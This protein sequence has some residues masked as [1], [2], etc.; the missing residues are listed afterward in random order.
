[1]KRWQLFTLCFVL[2]LPPVLSQQCYYPNGSI[3][4]HTA[5]LS[6]KNPT[7]CCPPGF[8]CLSNGLCADINNGGTGGNSLP[9]L[10]DRESCTDKTWSSPNC[11]TECSN[12]T[13]DDKPLTI[14][15][16]ALLTFSLVAYSGGSGDG[17]Q[18]WSCNAELTEY[19]CDLDPGGSYSNCCDLPEGVFALQLPSLLPTT[20]ASTSTTASSQSTTSTR[21]TTPTTT[22]ASSSSGA[23]QSS[24][25]PKTSDKKGLSSGAAAGIGVGV[26]LAGILGIA[27]VIWWLLRKRRKGKHTREDNTNA[28]PLEMDAR[29]K[30]VELP[31]KGPKELAGT[32]LSELEGS[33]RPH[34]TED[35]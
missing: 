31:R 15:C 6:G 20:L 5:C 26:G 1:M 3:A 27:L 25:Q 16:R 29:P 30:I 21:T 32:P 8:P 13:L 7:W 24:G 19:C 17:V 34:R 2:N 9:G 18:V 12:R 11:V 22:P 33:P 14:Y 10:Y 28:G 23:P 35:L 4:D